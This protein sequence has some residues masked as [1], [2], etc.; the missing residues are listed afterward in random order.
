MSR[1]PAQKNV[2]NRGA[3]SVIR[4][5]ENLLTEYQITRI[6]NINPLTLKKLVREGKIPFTKQGSR[7]RFDMNAISGWIANNPVIDGDEDIRLKRIQAE[8]LEKS[9]ELFAALRSMDIKVTARSDAQKNPKRY[10]LIKRASKKYGFLYYVRYIDNGKL[11]PSKWNTRTN[12]LQEAEDFARENRERILS[13]YYSK[14]ALRNTGNELYSV[15]GEYYKDGSLYLEKDKNRNRVLGEKARSVYYHFMRKNFIPYLRENNINAF[16]K[17]DP[18][19]IANFQDYFLSTGTKP[20]V[21]QPV[22]K[23]C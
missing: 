7:A 11:V 16:D 6:F 4:N 12:I 10:S 9:P 2:K 8:W 21:N 3:S 5:M 20:P 17:I 14:R 15:L 13:E 19:V 22:S 18:P 1:F 23:R